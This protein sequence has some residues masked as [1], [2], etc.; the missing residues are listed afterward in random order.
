MSIGYAY[1]KEITSHFV[2]ILGKK[3]GRNNFIPSFDATDN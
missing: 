2:P 1:F 3:G